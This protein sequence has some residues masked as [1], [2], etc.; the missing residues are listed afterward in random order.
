MRLVLSVMQSENPY[1]SPI[2]IQI[3]LVLLVFIASRVA[4]ADPYR[5]VWDSSSA[6]SRGSMPIGNGDIGLNVWVEPNGDLLFY[7]SKTDAWSGNGR[8]LKLGR[9]RIAFDPPLYKDGTSFRQE[10][11]LKRGL[12]TIQS[13]T[14]D[15]QSTITIWVD[16][17]QPVIRAEAESKTAFSLVASVELWRKERRQLTGDE[18]HS[19]YGLKNGPPVFVEPDTVA[20]ASNHRLRWYHR[21]DKSCYGITLKNQHLDKLLAK[22]PDPL[23]GRTFGGE[24]NGQ[25]MVSRDDRTLV[26]SKPQKRFVLSI[27][28]MTAQTE[29]TRDWF[30]R[31]DRRVASIDEDID[32]T[33][34]AH[35]QWW[36]KFWQRSWIHVSGDKNAETVT[37]AYALQRW[38]NACSGRGAYPIKFNGSIFTFDTVGTKIGGYGGYD[39]D[40]RLW[41]GCYWFQNTRLP[42]WSM[43]A[44]GDYDLIHPLWKMYRDALPMACDRTRLYYNHDGAFFPETMYFWGTY[45]NANFGWNNP[46]VTTTNT[47]IRYYWSGNIELTMMML[48]Y[49][50]HI[51][52][53]D[54][55]RQT[56][57]PLADA[58]VTFFD[59]HWKRVEDGKIRFE[60]AASLETWHVA[61]NPLPEIVGLR[62]VL[63]RLLALPPDLTTEARRT[64]WQKTLA[65]LPDVPI[66]ENHGKRFLLPA[67]KY[68]RLR[69]SE[70]PELYA[71]FPYRAYGVGKKDLPVALET[72]RR[73]RVKGTG[74]WAQDSIQA[75]YLGLTDEAKKMIV[76]NSR[77]EDSGSRFPAMWGP[78]FDWIPD[79]DHGSVT[80]IAL[81]RMLMQCEGKQILIAPAWPK[82]WDCDF[83]L[84]APYRTTVQGT[85]RG[86]KVTKLTVTPAARRHDVV[87]HSGD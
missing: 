5:V 24:M 55:A 83:K 16:A 75:A 36:A 61:T 52:D 66:R 39:A 60:P 70:N 80:T 44:A 19:A 45:N 68:S 40:F 84:H 1:L 17:N 14:N 51:G 43:L 21:N 49:Y 28:P 2:F 53:Q 67:E 27:Y 22:Y 4:A 63:R 78:N 85:I 30:R 81:Q 3:G 32:A 79:Q 57:L 37:Q 23:M 65:D 7:I 42:Y 48:D 58:I 56:L 6:N 69:N 18:L 13:T 15:Q 77:H 8:L 11:D 25:G 59:Q 71:V 38:I 87:I 9:V 29:R 82:D 54:F 33:R 50:Q 47:Y 10:L 20:P 41:G 76:S 72:W 26:S 35:E 64:A 12:I 86:G 31:L 62:V 46:T 34:R 74:G 73:R